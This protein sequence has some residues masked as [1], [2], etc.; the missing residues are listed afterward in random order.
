MGSAT[1]TTTTKTKTH[2]VDRGKW[3]RGKERNQAANGLHLM[4]TR[5]ME[6]STTKM[7]KK[8]CNLKIAVVLLLPS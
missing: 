5:R 6:F 4:K 8:S 1:T 2:E 7:S 3:W